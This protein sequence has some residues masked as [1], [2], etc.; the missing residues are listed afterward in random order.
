M[1]KS[2]GPQ[3]EVPTSYVNDTEGSVVEGKG[4]RLPTEKEVIKGHESAAKI[5][6]QAAKLYVQS[7]NAALT[8][9][10]LLDARDDFRQALVSKQNLLG[11]ISNKG[12]AGGALAKPAGKNIDPQK[13]RADVKKLE[14]QVAALDVEI[15][16]VTEQAK[17]A[18]KE[19]DALSQKA[20]A[21]AS[22]SKHKGKRLD[23]INLERGNRKLENATRDVTFSPDGA[24]AVAVALEEAMSKKT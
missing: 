11:Q 23:H 4:R 13:L 17:A 5:H 12:G 15:K 7:E 10:G 22:V 1:V 9:L 19:A 8:S 20:N 2:L 21:F 18:Q 14:A 16:S 24:K 6:K 3:R